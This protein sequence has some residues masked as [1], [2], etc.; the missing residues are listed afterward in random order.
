VD[1]ATGV[2]GFL[3]EPPLL[4]LDLLKVRRLRLW[5]GVVSVAHGAG[6]GMVTAGALKLL[7]D[8][9]MRCWLGGRGKLPT[10][11]LSLAA[12]G[13]GRHSDGER[14]PGEGWPGD[15]QGQWW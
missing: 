12:K 5:L 4:S 11:G 1:S 2:F 7:N 14:R 15:G 8:V 13:S 3:Y 9:E 10:G 6:T